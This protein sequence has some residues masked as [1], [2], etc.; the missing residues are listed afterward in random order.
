MSQRFCNILLCA[1][2]LYVYHVTKTVQ[3]MKVSALF[4]NIMVV[5]ALTRCALLSS[6]GDLKVTK[7]NVQRCQ[8]QERTLCE[9]E[10]GCNAAKATNNICFAKGD[11]AVKKPWI[12]RR[13]PSLRGKSSEWYPESIRRFWHFLAQYGSLPSR[14][15]QK[16]LVTKI[17]QNF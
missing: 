2:L 15:R 1:I 16:S 12:P 9:F 8:I 10:L 14:S 6:V 13:A 3:A 4:A 17:L 11:S 7:M 5:G